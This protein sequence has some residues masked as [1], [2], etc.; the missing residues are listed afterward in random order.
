MEFT[1]KQDDAAYSGTGEADEALA[2]AAQKSPAAFTPLYRRYVTRVYCY[3]Y[4]RVGNVTETEDLTAQVFADALTA[5]PKY[6]SQG[7][8]AG[9]L[10]TFAY[11]RCADYHRQPVTEPLSEQLIAGPLQDPAGQ[12]EQQELFHHLNHIL[13]GLDFDER[14][15]LRLRYAAGLSY[16]EMASVLGRSEGAVKMAI[17]RLINKMKAQWEVGN[18]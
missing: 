18:E 12:A 17:S 8:F 16:L 5:L 14:E 6:R 7:H 11:R 13:N 9:W 1:L 10:F 15:L 3:I 4:S 2:Q